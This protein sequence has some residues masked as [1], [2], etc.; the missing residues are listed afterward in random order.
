MIMPTLNVFASVAIP[1]DVTADIN[2]DNVNAYYNQA[3]DLIMRKYKFDI[4]K[5]E[6]YKGTIENLLRNNPELLEEAFR[7]M[8][9]SL[10]EHSVYYTED[11]LNSFLNDMTGEICG[12]GVL[13]T[14]AEAGLLV[15]NVYDNTPAKEAGVMQGDIITHAGGVF[16][17][18]L[19][20]DLAKQ[21]VIG[22]E[23]TP[24]TITILRGEQSFDKTLIRRKVVVD[25]GFY[26]IVE[27]GKIGYIELSEF[28][29]TAAEFVE[30][31]LN[32]FDKYG[33]KDII[34]D[35]RSNPGGGLMEFVDVCSLF[36]PTGPVIHL[37]YKNPLRFTTLYSKNNFKQP[38]YNLAVLINKY[39][40]SAAEAFSAAVQDS[41]V[42]IVIGE[43]SYGKGTMQNITQFKIGGGVKITEA[44][45][46][47]PNRRQ[48]NKVGVT[49]DVNAPDKI[50][51]YSK[52]DIEPLTY[53]RILKIGDTGKDVL[54]VE[55]RLRIA[56]FDV[57]VPDEVYD[58]KTHN[59]T[60]QFQAATQLFQ[61]GVM[62]YTTQAKI[63]NVLSG[64][65][66]RSDTSYK[67]AVEIFKTGH[68]KDYRLD[69]SNK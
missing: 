51:D 8:F 63:E 3:I 33:I 27:D 50:S 68:W 38:K 53:E 22:P 17:G 67:K 5:E 30:K 49:P 18:G 58:E 47:S 12:I 36:I 25:A 34:F 48:V 11:E 40:A 28:N 57:G 65:E 64:L 1:E 19:D 56:G 32:E 60:L 7:S 37:D 15:S 29:D 6:L 23:N 2:S 46:L 20:I 62:D 9:E 55:E 59:A 24:V 14:T 69:W 26:Q 39:S 4:T 43:Q 44:E 45:Y 21:H 42:G 10:D 16:L 13:I 61:Y 35:L 52:A 31:A 54:A 41:G 66:V